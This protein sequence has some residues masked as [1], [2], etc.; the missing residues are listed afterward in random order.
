MPIQKKNKIEYNL[1]QMK[2]FLDTIKNDTPTL[3]DF[4]AEWCSPCKSM[5]PILEELKSSIGNKAT[6]LKIDVEKNQ[7][8]SQQYQV[9]NVPT[10]ILFKNG[11]ILWRHSGSISLSNLNKIISQY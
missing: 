7:Q 3:V 11:N 8:V 4:Y 10:F 9:R 5:N 6:I 1:Q 2:T